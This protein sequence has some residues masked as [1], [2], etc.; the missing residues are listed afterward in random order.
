MFYSLEHFFI[1]GNTISVAKKLL[2]SY[3]AQNGKLIFFTKCA[4][5]H[6]FF[7][8]LDKKTC[9]RWK[10]SKCVIYRH[11]STSRLPKRYLNTLL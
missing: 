3:F 8:I 9:K 10:M 1:I 6:R 2:S 11:I 5:F 4:V 7:T